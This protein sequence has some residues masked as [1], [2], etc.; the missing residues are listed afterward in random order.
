MTATE[1]MSCARGAKVHR[2]IISLSDR[3]S[4]RRHGP[5]DSHNQ[6][7]NEA[8]ARVV[9][10]NRIAMEGHCRSVPAADSGGARGTVT[11]AGILVLG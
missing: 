5:H 2:L 4:L 3:C 6:T 11:A 10:L 7:H 9:R 1:D 8:Q